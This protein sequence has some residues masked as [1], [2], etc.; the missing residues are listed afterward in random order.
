MVGIGKNIN[1]YNTQAK[2]A[3][4]IQSELIFV[5]CMVHLPQE[6]NF[7]S[8]TILPSL[9]T[10]PSP[11]SD[12]RSDFPAYVMSHILFTTYKIIACIEH[13]TMLQANITQA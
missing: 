6:W 8:P 9:A 1:Q 11:R 4:D 12:S 2:E 13:A 10:P 5:I 7:G 3:L